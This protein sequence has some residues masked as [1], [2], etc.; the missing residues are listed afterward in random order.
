MTYELY[1]SYETD[2]RVAICNTYGFRKNGQTALKSPNKSAV[3]NLIVDQTLIIRVKLLKF[4]RF[5][6]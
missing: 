3:D 1:E 5:S 4:A 6:L 2:Y